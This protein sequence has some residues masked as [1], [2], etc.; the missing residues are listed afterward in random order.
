MK[1]PSLSPTATDFVSVSVYFNN[2]KTLVA[3][4]RGNTASFHGL[5]PYHLQ[6]VILMFYFISLP[7]EGNSWWHKSWFHSH[8]L[9]VLSL[10]VLREW[11][12]IKQSTS[13]SKCQEYID[14]YIH[15]IYFSFTYN[16]NQ[17]CQFKQQVQTIRKPILSE[18]FK[19]ISSVFWFWFC[20]VFKLCTYKV[21]S[22][23]SFYKVLV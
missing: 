9:L 15:S 20:F 10:I 23:Y 12:T 5:F 7:L 13:Y 22:V 19:G 16:L 14:I 17:H 4:Y 1:T 6:N 18:I 2:E 21:V 3:V 11:D 8:P